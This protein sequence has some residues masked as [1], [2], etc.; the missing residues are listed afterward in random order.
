MK[1]DLYRLFKSRIDQQITRGWMKLGQLRDQKMGQKV[2]EIEKKLSL[3]YIQE[4]F[5]ALWK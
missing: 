1:Q 2:S 5:L 4:Q 3:S